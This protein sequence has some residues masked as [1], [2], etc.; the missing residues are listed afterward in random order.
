MTQ[1]QTEGKVSEEYEEWIVQDQDTF[2]WLLNTIFESVLPCILSCNHAYEVWD[3]NHKYFNA[4]MKAQVRQLCV[5]L[6]SIKK[7]NS[8]ITEY[9]LCVKAIANSLLVVGDI[10]YKQD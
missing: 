10:V 9:V 6:K 4:H 7:G 3:K 5:K 8:T 1:D 2:I